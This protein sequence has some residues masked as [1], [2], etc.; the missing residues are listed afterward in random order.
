MTRNILLANGEYYHVFN[1]GVDKRQIFDDAIDYH[2][3]IESLYLFNDVTFRNFGGDPLL[4]DTILSSHE[5]FAQDRV[6]L[7]DIVSYCLMPNHFHLLLRQRQDDGVSKFLHKLGM[8]YAKYFNL[9]N[10]RKGSL[11]EST[12]GAKHVE[13]ESHL[14]HLPRYI[15]FNALDLFGIHWR[16]SRIEN[17]ERAFDVLARYRWSSHHEYMGF[18]NDLPIIDQDAVRD[19]FKDPAD[20]STFLREWNGENEIPSLSDV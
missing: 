6:P 16:G 8:G 3:F 2:R 20:Y 1:R 12:F 5:V 9:R 17:W 19:I 11:F 13:H 15:H 14:I 7:V 4:R 18:T 10:N